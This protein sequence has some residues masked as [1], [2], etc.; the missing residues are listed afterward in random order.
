MTS[1]SSKKA[2]L[3]QKATNEVREF[4][5]IF[6]YVAA[7]LIVLTTYR[8]LLLDEFHLKYF[9]YGAA[10]TEALIA[11]KVI[12]LGDYLQL[13]KKHTNKPIFVSAAYQAV[14]FGLLLAAFHTLEEVVKGLFHGQAVLNTLREIRLNE[15]LLRS[16]VVVCG[17]ITFFG[18][19]EVRRALGDDKF[20]SLFFGLRPKESDL[21][22]FQ[23]T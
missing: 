10:L 14:L 17:F 20:F 13:G 19:R 3:K 1:P 22:G 12:M 5:A 8:M 2:V 6:L 4:M 16:L 21:S 23:G 18:Y 9:R 15:V 11:T 7:F